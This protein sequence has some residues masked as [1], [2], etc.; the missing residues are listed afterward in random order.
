MTALEE[1]DGIHGGGGRGRGG[2]TVIR[3]CGP[4]WLFCNC[5][6]MRQT[7]TKQAGNQ[8][9]LPKDWGESAGNQWDLPK[10]WGESAGNQRDLPKDWGE[11]AGNQ[12]DLPKDWG[13]S[14]GNQ[15][16]LPKDWGESAGNQ[17]DLPN[18]WG[19]SAGTQRDLPKDWGESAVVQDWASQKRRGNRPWQHPYKDNAIWI[20]HQSLNI[21]LY[22]LH[23]Y[24]IVLLF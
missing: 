1:Q 5:R 10:D 19:E 12:W 22:L 17:R 6:R 21:F 18:D 24:F 20:C 16:D 15:W 13:E 7:S 2:D 11:S 14:A 23:V 9:D 3:L 4:V 8:R